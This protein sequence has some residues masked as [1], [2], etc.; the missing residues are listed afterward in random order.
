MGA[1]LLSTVTSLQRRVFEHAAPTHE[2]TRARESRE[3]LVGEREG[4][5]RAWESSLRT[6]EAALH[7][8]SAEASAKGK[9]AEDRQSALT[10]V[11]EVRGKKSGSYP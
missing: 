1:L 10:N 9:Q 11:E 4:A 7:Q 8:A 2:H 6:G 3:R 5:A